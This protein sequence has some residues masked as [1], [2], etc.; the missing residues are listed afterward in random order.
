[1]TQSNNAQFLPATAPSQHAATLATPFQTMN[2]GATALL[3]ASRSGGALTPD[4]DA[5]I[6]RV[7]QVI[8]DLPGVLTVRDQG[9]SSDG[10]ARKALV[11]TNG[12][13]GNAGNPTLVGQIRQ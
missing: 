5:A 12:N 6:Q 2:V 10:K 9:R 3:V 8:S 11:V 4:D 1:M 7:E 13:G